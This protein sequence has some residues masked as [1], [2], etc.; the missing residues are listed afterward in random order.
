MGKEVVG[1]CYV[2]ICKCG[3][4]VAAVA[5]HIDTYDAAKQR[6]HQHQVAQDVALFNRLGL[7][8]QERDTDEVRKLW[9]TCTCAKP[10]FKPQQLVMR[11]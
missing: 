8:I 6:R 10:R 2:G 11:L 4:I 5:T 1:R 9:H 3:Q 7:V